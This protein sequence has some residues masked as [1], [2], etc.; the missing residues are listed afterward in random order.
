MAQFSNLE[1]LRPY[2]R[3][4]AIPF[5]REVRNAHMLARHA[6]PSGAPV[7]V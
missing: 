7:S 1:A 6:S 5:G 3:P 4:E 2:L